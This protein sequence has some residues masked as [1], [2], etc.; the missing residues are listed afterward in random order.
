METINCNPYNL[1]KDAV[2]FITGCSSGIGEGLA[3][4]L[5][6]Q[7]PSQR[8]VATA[9]N[10]AALGNIPDEAGRV[11]K[12]ALDVTS[13][14]SIDAALGAAAAHFG[15]IDVVVSNAGYTLM[16]DA[17]GVA[18]DEA[19]ALL[20]T[21]FWGAAEVA[22]RALPVLREVKGSGGGGGQQQQQQ[23]Q[24]GGVL[25]FVSSLGGFVGSPG[26]AFYHASK[27]A[28]E[29]FAQS[30]GKELRPEWGVS[31]TCVEPGGVRSEF[32]GRG[33]RA[34]ER[35]P[36]YAAADA[37]TSVMLRVLADV[38]VRRSFASPGQTARAIYDLLRS[39][40]KLPVRCPLGADAWA[41]VNRETERV[42]QELREWKDLS[43]SVGSKESKDAM[44]AEA[45]KIM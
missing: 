7:T 14:A 16:G 10:P 13:R 40:R 5:C 15:R 28:L 26:A 41:M 43:C 37:P 2:W 33:F 8:V 9:R 32:L 29:G 25:V 3:Q 12:L 11:L 24:R 34:A 36:A 18:P 44:A 6:T 4:Y 27:F 21:N 23:Q 1:P 19:R 42:Q 38:Q 45:G 39:G 35:H 17:E 31:V 22:T 30:L 20:D